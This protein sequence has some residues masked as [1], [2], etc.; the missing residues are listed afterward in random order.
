MTPAGIREVAAHAGVSVGTVSNF[1]NHPDRLSEAMARRVT[2]A[3]EAVGFVPSNAARQLRMGVS[4]VIGYLASDIGNPHFGEIAT[5]VQVRASQL[6]LSVFIAD[7]Q[8]DPHR[9]DAYLDTFAQHHVRGL[10][11]ASHHP[12]EDRLAL[13]R[14]R[15]T[16]SVLVGQRATSTEQPSVSVDEFSGGRQAIEHLVEVGC[17]AIAFVGGPAQIVQVAARRAG[18][19]AAALAHGVELREVVV[20]ERSVAAGRAA[21]AIIAGMTPEERPDG[22][23]AVNDLLALGVLQELV[24]QG[25]RVPQDVALIGYDDT[26]FAEASLIPL[27]SVS[28]RHRDAGEIVVD[29]L[30]ETMEQRSP[31]ELHRELEPILV[32]RQSTRG[33]LRD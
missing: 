12:V 32:V 28:R 7:A 15:G 24:G 18:A 25:I 21:G 10:L 6:G 8:E 3:I 19:D 20:A 16:P 31:A 26:E 14:R 4:S 23:F 22:V 13:L 17:R 29:A 9:E 2:D 33:F 1:L 30:F 27:S 5:S 11:V